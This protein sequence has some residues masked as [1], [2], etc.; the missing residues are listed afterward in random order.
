MEFLKSIFG[1]KS[2][3]YDDMVKAIEAH[4]GNEANKENQIKIGNLGG[5]EYVG[6]GKHDSDVQKLNDLLSS[7]DTDIK[8]LQDALDSLKKGNV[9]ADAIKSKLAGVEKQL[10]DSKAKEAQTVLKYALRDA[11]REA[12]VKDVGYMEYLITQKLKD[13]GKT[14]ELDESEHIKGWDDILSGM[15]T[16]KPE[17]FEKA[18]NG[19]IQVE[20]NPL[21]TNNT[22]GVAMTRSEFLKKPYA[23][24]AAYAKDNPEAYKEI[25]NQ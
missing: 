11:L 23:E 6:K 18:G 8:T 15:K 10:A 16:Q 24:R 1:D 5:G 9:D 25:M 14:L 7:K 19:G 17:Q 13:E 22:N 4:N 20:A 3:T 21:P 12:K 2:L